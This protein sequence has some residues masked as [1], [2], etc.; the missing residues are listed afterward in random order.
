MTA[1]P[2]QADRSRPI[3][4]GEIQSIKPGD[5]AELCKRI[6]AED[7]ERFAR[8][9]GDLNPLH[10][11]AEY[12]RRTSFQRPV[13]HGML[14]ASY[15]STLIGMQVPGP[16]A[17]W[18]SQSFRW[19][20]PVFVDDTLTVSL[21]VTQ[22]SMGSRTI[23]IEISAMNQNG[24]T[25]LEGEGAVHVLETASR[26]SEP[27]LSNQVAF[28]AGSGTETN[29]ATARALASRG[30]KILLSY[31]KQA[32]GAEETCHSIISSGGNA[33]AL[34][35]DLSSPASIED[36]LRNGQEHFGNAASVLINDAGR[37]QSGKAITELTWA[38]ME[39]QIAQVRS[40][41][42]CAKAVIPAMMDRR[43]GRIVNV[44]SAQSWGRPPVQSAPSAVA[45][46]ALGA[47]TRCLAVE[48][49]P[50]GIRVNMISPGMAEGDLT[51]VPERLRKVE[52]MQ[53][54][55]RRL[56]TAADIAET[57]V[58]LCSES[59]AYITGADI[60][61]TGGGRM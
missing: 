27:G 28:V 45:S 52:A 11:D 8:L 38:D 37:V 40:A 2:E 14:V 51:E 22:V 47:L 59:S 33:I 32:A 34:Q 61:V 16:G 1:P 29:R 48:L 58:W 39:N 15:V 60:P 35:T 3:P 46:A 12:A 54:P 53:T 24:K 31:R 21:T 42:L 19:P 57:V 50:S 43:F 18:T 49:G 44:G 41:F 23:K 10:V 20:A 30:V 4:F 25:V 17:L 6:T 13:V 5:R 55:L 7:V 36:T 26:P 9:S 56:A